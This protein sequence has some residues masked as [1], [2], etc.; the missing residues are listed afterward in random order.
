MEKPG[1]LTLDREADIMERGKTRQE[2]RTV[3]KGIKIML[4]AAALLCLLAAGLCWWQWDNIRALKTSMEH[5]R[6]DLSDLIEEN[7]K[8]VE[9]VANRLPVNV[10]DLTEEERQ[11]LYDGT[12]DWDALLDRLT[13]KDQPA[14]GEK[15]GETAPPAGENAPSQPPSSSQPEVTQPVQP[16][17]SP[18][19]QPTQPPEEA[20]P[21]QEDEDL[22]ARYIAEIYLMKAEYTKW[23]EDAYAAAIEEYVAL[24]EEKRTATA[25][26]EIGMRYMRQALDKEDECDGR[27]A[28]LEEKIL[29]LLQ[30]MGEDTSLVDEIRAAYKEEKEL[31]KAYYL[32]LHS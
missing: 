21:S 32:G 16:E 19:M 27:M 6:E 10:R 8:R 18:S 15:P 3:K 29:A 13:G 28:E 9:D 24:P 1:G 11:A 14:E 25:K 23:L 5:S 2:G 4:F 17:T 30:K 12:M 31:K 22:L 7:D 20:A 26:Y